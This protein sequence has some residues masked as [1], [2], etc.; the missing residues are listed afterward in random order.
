MI[1][2]KVVAGH[3]TGTGLYYN[4]SFRLK[5]IDSFSKIEI[6]LSDVQAIGE[7]SQQRASIAKTAGYGLAGE[8]IAGPMGAL[9]GVF[10]ASSR[11]KSIVQVTLPDNKTFLAEM[12]I[13]DR[14]AIER[15]YFDL[16]MG[17]RNH[18]PMKDK[19]ALR[20]IMAI[21]TALFI[22]AICNK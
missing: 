18:R 9:A 14:Q 10:L 16:K 8:V 19:M 13:D 1:N 3:F 17:V 5:P 12:N 7:F 22:F 20:I 15:D 6:P 2:F 4:R 11:G 21:L